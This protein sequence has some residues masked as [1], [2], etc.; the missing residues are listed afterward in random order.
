[1]KKHK[2]LFFALILLVAGTLSVTL[3]SCKTSK[4]AVSS[5]KGTVLQKNLGLQLYSIRDSIMRNV[6]AA[7]EKVAKM[8]YKFVEPANYANG[9]I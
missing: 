2:L 4:P 6:P 5:S 7:I 1:M 9:K 8:G 3:Y